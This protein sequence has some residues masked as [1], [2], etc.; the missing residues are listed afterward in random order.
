MQITLPKAEVVCVYGLPDPE[1]YADLQEWLNENQDSYVVF[2]EEDEYS[3]LHFPI[4]HERIRV[5]CPESDESLKKIA[6]EFVF[7]KFDYLD[8]PGNS[9]KDPSKMKK[10]FARMNFFQEGIHLVA[11]DF[12]EKGIDKL[13]NY[14]LNAELMEKA[15]LGKGLFGKF[16]GIPALICGAGAS[17]EKEIPFLEKWR[18]RAL[19]FAGGTTLSSLFTFGVKPHFAGHI[20]PHVP[21]KRHFLYDTKEIPIFFQNRTHP[22]LLKESG[23]LLWIPGS[24][25]DLLEEEAFDGGW[26]VSTFLTSIAYHL[27]C[28]PIILVG[29]D[30]AQTKEKAYAGN[31]ERPEEGELIALEKEGLYTR[32]DWLFA[33]E[34][35]MQFAKKHPEIEWINTSFEGVTIEGFEK[36]PL[37]SLS[38]QYSRDLPSLIQEAISS[39]PKKSVDF[40]EIKKLKESFGRI[41][42]LCIRILEILEQLFPHSPEKNGEYALLQREVENE[43][44][45]EKFILPVW[46]IWKPV[47]ARQMPKEIPPAFGIELNQW[48]FIQGICDDARKI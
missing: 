1:L 4:E 5:C 37:Q 7:L 42:D 3:L 36:K 2:L 12:Q 38:L 16:R 6:W 25:N 46:K 48:L 10:L 41:G 32:R 14:L 43:M 29:V 17:L 9:S 33:A 21:S 44:A 22:K 35:L 45:F 8:I 13:R 47:F 28:N 31:L 15:L 24:E 20:D 11:S 23:Q 27:G 19:I 40:T 39:L 30:L 34:W 26:N 18:D